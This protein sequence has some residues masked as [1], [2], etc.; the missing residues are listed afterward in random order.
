MNLN[1]KVVLICVSAS[2]AISKAC[3]LC[4]KLRQSGASVHVLMTPNA[5]K[6]I[7]PLTFQALTGNPVHTD[8]FHARAHGDIEH[9]EL[10]EKADVTVVAPATAN[11]IAKIAHG[12]SDHLLTSTILACSAP[13]LIAPA[14]ESRMWNHPATQENISTLRKRGASIL[15]PESGWL[16][17]GRSGKGRMIGTERVISAIEKTLTPNHDLEKLSI[18]VT[19]GATRES[20]DPTRF[21]SN[22]SS[23]KMGY[24]IAEAAKLRG[25]NALIV[26][27]S[28]TVPHPEGIDVVGVES[29]DEMVE[30]VLSHLNDFN[31]LISAA[32]IADFRPSS[33]ASQKIKRHGQKSMTLELEQTPDLVLS[34]RNHNQ[35][36]FIV[37]FAA[38]TQ[39]VISNARKK[40]Q[41]KDAD[42]IVANDITQEGAGF[43]S[44]TNIVTLIDRDGAA[45][46]LPKMTK[47]D[48]ANYLLDRIIIKKLQ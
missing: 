14:M 36:L 44:D 2:I 22:R 30:A 5:T 20:I 6:L 40:L 16:A 26:S 3:D 41:S 17:S 35:Q 45:E 9:V 42:L 18:I 47:L 23:G 37:C 25:A 33:F 15:E 11:L 4:S 43:D 24:A 8:M 32:A 13:L 28:A 31:V 39:N 10:A 46:T 29:A 12:I 34:A 19:A 27:G 1:G 21:I 38:E 7:T 48:V